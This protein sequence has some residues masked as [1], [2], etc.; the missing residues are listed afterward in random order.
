MIPHK[1]NDL[2]GHDQ[3]L[4]FDNRS[5]RHRS[6]IEQCIASLK[7][8]RRVHTRFDKLALSFLAVVTLAVVARHLRT[9]IEN[10]ASNESNASAR[11]HA[12]GEE[13]HAPQRF[14]TVQLRALLGLRGHR[15]PQRGEE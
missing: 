12:S 15:R 9:G 5:L 8:P 10:R 11:Q 4:G 2:L 13:W 3:G 6:V 14:D 1:D 7:E